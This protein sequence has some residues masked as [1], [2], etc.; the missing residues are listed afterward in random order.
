M[1]PKP[2]LNYA[3]IDTCEDWISTMKM[4]QFYLPS[5]FSMQMFLNELKENI[6]HL[7]TI[8]IFESLL[9]SC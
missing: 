4:Y 2:N 9:G 7:V 3:Y 5:S 8:Q 1:F 6:K